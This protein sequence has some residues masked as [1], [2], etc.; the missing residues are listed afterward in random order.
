MSVNFLSF[1]GSR[2]KVGFRSRCCSGKG[3]HLALRGESPGFSRAEAANLGFL[4]SYDGD[5]RDPLVSPQESPVSLRVARG[6]SGFL[7][8]HCWGRGPHVEVRPEPQG[9]SPLPTWISGFLWSFHR[10]VSTRLVWR[11]ASPLSSQAGKAASCFLLSCHR[12]R[13]LSL[14]VPQGCHTCHCILI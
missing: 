9:S 12:D 5:F 4:S 7:C 13:W 1:Q 10:G 3:P 8:I 6:L 14:E 2:G 11:H